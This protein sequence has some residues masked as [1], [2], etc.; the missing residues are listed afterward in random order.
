MTH[1]RAVEHDCSG[2]DDPGRR[3]L[4][5]H[6]ARA[7]EN[8]PISGVHARLTS[9]RDRALGAVKQARHGPTGN[10]ACS[11]GTAE[12]I[13]RACE[14]VRAG[15]LHDQFVVD[16]VQGGAGTSTNMNANEV[17]ANR[18]LELWAARWATTAGCTPTTTSTG[19]RAP[20]TST[21][22]Q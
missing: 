12:A 22:Q 6:T 16:A 11:T 4:G 8:F 19:A 13:D 21:R 7:L 2:P 1:R 14:D 10:S 17:I 15:G 3:L 18:A 20:T 5:I 9:P